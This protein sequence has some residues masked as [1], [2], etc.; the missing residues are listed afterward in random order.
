MRNLILSI[1]FISKTGSDVIIV[2][3]CGVIQVQ[4]QYTDLKMGLCLRIIYAYVR[5]GVI[6][7]LHL[8]FAAT[9]ISRAL[10]DSSDLSWAAVFSP[11]FLF[12]AI[13]IVYLVIYIAGLIRDIVDGD[14]RPSNTSCFP[15]Q[16]AGPLPPIVYGLALFFK[17]IGEILLVTFLSI[18]SPP[19]YVSAIFFM[20]ML[21]VATAGFFVYSVK[22]SFKTF[23][24]LD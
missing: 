8:V 1:R 24:H 6:G 2:R 18:G 13:S 5:L 11:L 4:T 23:L 9:V 17:V 14:S 15:H 21:L 16:Q 20:L 7:G 10:D 12:D 3:V 19:F 22:P